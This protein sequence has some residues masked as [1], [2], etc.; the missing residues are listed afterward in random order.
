[1]IPREA[2]FTR[3]R[4][5]LSRSR[6]VALLG[7]RQA[8]KT[9]LAL[10][11]A[12]E[13]PPG[14]SHLFD[15]EDPIHEARLTLAKQVLNPLTGLIILDEIQLRPDLF[16]LLRVLADRLPLPARFLLL[17]SASPDLIRGASETLA[18]RIEFIEVTGFTLPETGP[19]ARDQL[20]LR[21]GFPLSFLASSDSD[22]LAWRQAFIRTFLE[23][24]LRNFGIA[25][26]PA[27]LRR[28]WQMLAHTHGSLLNTAELGRALGESAQTVRRHLEILQ[29]AFMIHTLPPWFENLGKR[30]VKHPK[31]YLCDPGLLHALLVLETIHDL[32]GHPKCGA[33]WE[34]FCLREILAAAGPHQAFFWAT[35]AGAELDL[36]LLRGPRRLGFECKL[37]ETPR[38]SKS[39]HAA[40]AD[41]RLDELTVVYP[42]ADCFPLADRIY[43]RPLEQA[44]ALVA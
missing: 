26:S 37:T 2:L 6:I 23:R 16:P 28:L 14:S 25:T 20:W 32:R 13:S 24:D 39:M 17:G 3:V 18:G 38:T 1:M 41:L 12:A 11:L 9:T 36:L 35:H 5:A 42:G 30:L 29:G 27:A 8:G 33:S 10:Q 40:L 7:P 43:A 44:L 19:S 34:G 21:G 15:L 31:V 22:S 4:H